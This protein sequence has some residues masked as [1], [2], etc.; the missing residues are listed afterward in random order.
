MPQAAGQPQDNIR[1]DNHDAEGG[2]QHTKKCPDLSDNLFE[3][4]A[5]NGINDK[6]QN[7]I[8]W[9]RIGVLIS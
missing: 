1:K 5:R 2:Q 8:G 9:G 7:T 4:N 3:G 6:E